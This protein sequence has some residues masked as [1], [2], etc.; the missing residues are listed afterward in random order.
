M[1]MSS[2][3]GAGGQ[4]DCIFTRLLH[5]SFIGIVSRP[6]F[7]RPAQNVQGWLILRPPVA[8]ASVPTSVSRYP[9]TPTM[10]LC[11]SIFAS[12]AHVVLD[13]TNIFGERPEPRH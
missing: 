3:K 5:V 1:L 4:D 2:G 8:Q 11:G 7:P 6:S 9:A 10:P 12:P 13:V